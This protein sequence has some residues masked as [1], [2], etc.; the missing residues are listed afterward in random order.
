MFL[1]T[2]KPVFTSLIEPVQMLSD[3]AFPAQWFVDLEYLAELYGAKVEF[4]PYHLSENIAGRYKKETKTCFI[5]FPHDEYD[6]MPTDYVVATFCHELAH[7]IQYC[8]LNAEK[9][10][11]LA[12]IFAFEQEACDIAYELTQH[13]FPCFLNIKQRYLD[14]FTKKS[15][16]AFGLYHNCS[17]SDIIEFVDNFVEPLKSPFVFEEVPCKITCDHFTVGGQPVESLIDK[18]FHAFD[19]PLPESGFIPTIPDYMVPKSFKMGITKK[20][21]TQVDKDGNKTRI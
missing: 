18:N 20:V 12:E 8:T 10:T 4:A 16:R 3:F 7:H 11:K 1:K 15:L 14:G 21:V 5:H 17:E 6:I 13:H 9:R 2:A 19:E